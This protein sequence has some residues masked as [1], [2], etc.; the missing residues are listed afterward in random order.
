MKKAILILTL[1]LAVATT[2]CSA[3]N[4]LDDP[5][6][7]QKSSDSADDG[8]FE[9][10]QESE[11]TSQ[12]YE[13]L[14]EADMEG[15]ELRF[16]NYDNTWLTWAINEL[17]VE[18][19]S[20]DLV[21]DE[22]YLRNRRIEERYNCKITETKV[23]NPSDQIRNIIRS[24]EDIYDIAHVYDDFAHNLYI[25]GSLY[26]WEQLPHIDLNLP[27]WLQDANSVFQIHGKQFAATGAYSLAL[28]TRGF[29]LLYNKDMY[30]SLGITDNMYDMA[31][32]STWTID[33][34][35]KI[36]KQAV[37]DLNGD[38]VMDGND[39]YGVTTAVKLHFGSLV[40]GAGVKYI[41]TDEQGNPYFAI[42]GNAYALEVMQKIF[43]LHNGTNIFYK[44]A[45]NLHDGSGDAQVFFGDQK[46]LFV[47]ASTRGIANYRGY[48][49]DIGILPFPKYTEQQEKY[50]TLVSGAGIAILP[51]TINASR[52]E[53]IGLLIE[54]LSRDSYQ[55]LLPA[56]KEITLKSKYARDDE[57]ADMID[58]IFNSLTFDFGLSVFPSET[59]YAYMENYFKMDNSFA[60][61]TE[62]LEPRVAS[63]IKKLIDAAQ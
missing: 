43:D 28:Y 50:Y 21:L 15:F 1:I 48:E 19:Q 2:A 31:K 20:G 53:N 25:E 7:N 52:F 59:Y 39:R 14:P 33:E 55:N 16:Y 8:Q 40:T 46:A 47:G 56:Y 35:A 17:D 30:K 24:G 23:G 61:T 4:G 36:A 49:F 51:I 3:P 37:A 22:I 18:E 60:S 63:A 12:E 45:G 54:A 32:E 42:P 57:S 41:D 38:G 62:K 13:K 44:I 27:W 10:Q 58:I 6:N 5:Q 29:V 9:G 11:E 34:F 26:T